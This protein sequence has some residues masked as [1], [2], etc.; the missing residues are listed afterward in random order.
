[1]VKMMEDK[2]ES[3]AVTWTQADTLDRCEVTSNII[4]WRY[5]YVLYFKLSMNIIMTKMQMQRLAIIELT[6]LFAFMFTSQPK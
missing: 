6:F 4:T 3:L 1:M 2:P 5:V